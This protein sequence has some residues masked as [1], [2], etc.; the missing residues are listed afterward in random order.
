MNSDDESDSE[1]IAKKCRLPLKAIE[2]EGLECAIWPHLYWTTAMCETTLRMANRTSADSSS[3]GDSASDK[4]SD[5]DNN[6]ETNESKM[7]RA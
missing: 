4:E 2:M 1:G 7:R 5:E 3:D 6:V